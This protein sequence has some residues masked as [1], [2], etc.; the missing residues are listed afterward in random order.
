MT[1]LT[2][3]R[4]SSR[5]A[6]AASARASGIARATRA[7]AR[8]GGGMWVNVFFAARSRV[9]IDIHWHVEPKSSG[10]PRPSPGSRACPRGSIHDALADSRGGPLRMP[11]DPSP[12]REGA[13]CRPTTI[14]LE[15]VLLL[16]ACSERDATRLT[17]PE[18]P[19]T[20]SSEA[21][22]PSI[23]PTGRIE[24][25]APSSETGPAPGRLAPPTAG[26]EPTSAPGPSASAPDACS[27]TST[28]DACTPAPPDAHAPPDAPAPLDPPTPR[29][30]L[31]AFEQRCGTGGVTP[32]GAEALARLPYLQRLSDGG[33]DILYKR[34]AAVAPDVVDIVDVSLP[35][36]SIVAHV[37]AVVDPGAPDGLQR[38]AHVEALAPAT[39]Y[40]YAIA[41]LTTRIGFRTA[42]PPGAD[43]SVRFAVF[44]DSG[45]GGVGQAAVRDRLQSLPAD[46]IL[47][48]GDV[49]YETGTLDQFEQRFFRVYQRMLESVPIFPIAGNHEH[50][51]TGAGPFLEV[52]DLP[53]NGSEFGREYWYS[54][55]FGDV[56]FVGLDTEQ[57]GAEQEAWLDRDL[58]QSHRRWTVVYFHRPPFS[59]GYHGNAA[60]VEQAFV[61]ILQSH[62]VPIVFA[63]HEHSYE[64][65]RPIG[66]VTYVITGG[67]GKRLRAVGTSDSTV[68]SQSV[69]HLMEVEV[70]G[71][72]MHVRAI[73]VSGT[74]IDA[75]D[76]V[77]PG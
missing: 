66:G 50:Y 47:H 2:I 60:D 39:Y 62:G 31:A 46:L 5:Q 59:A 56:H 27:P 26:V 68:K 72:S 20:P 33:V 41:G 25:S 10:K 36:G 15:L 1:S 40:C 57:L 30:A 76:L 51:S 34:A 69:L 77:A 16:G 49:A 8:G 19:A 12:R 23:A 54:F 55:D 58:S 18:P 65:T 61:P 29:G 71:P 35:D 43:A 6:S 42:P 24:P 17:I 52:F 28:T 63:G 53:E 75:F 7:A 48:T 64:R 67:G 70:H 13:L 38:L 4:A 3:M 37:S 74:E 14:A 44:G 73:D 22:T 32:R 21:S 45:D 9:N 11:F